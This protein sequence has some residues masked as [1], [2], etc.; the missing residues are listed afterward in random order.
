MRESFGTKKTGN[1][2]M[3]REIGLEVQSE[4]NIKAAAA[5]ASSLVMR[6]IEEVT[7]TW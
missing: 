6:G 5:A 2:W 4:S 1:A 7:V 3:D